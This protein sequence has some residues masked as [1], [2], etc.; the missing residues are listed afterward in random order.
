MIDHYTPMSPVG[1]GFEA[2]MTYSNYNLNVYTKK[3][4]KLIW[5]L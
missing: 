3:N 4:P 1:E 5:K 2:G